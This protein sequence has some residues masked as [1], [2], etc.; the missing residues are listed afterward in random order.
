MVDRVIVTIICKGSNFDMELPAN[1]E[2]SQLIPV[3]SE[4][5]MKKGVSITKNFRFISNES[6]LNNLDTL[7]DAGIWDGSN[8][9]V[10]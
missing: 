9:T 7:F 6:Y 1:V 2:I 5:L 8:L 10:V 4:A 3:I